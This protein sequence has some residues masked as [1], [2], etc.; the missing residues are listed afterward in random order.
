MSDD[1]DD[2]PS[3]SGEA[4]TKEQVLAVYNHMRGRNRPHGTGK[5]LDEMLALGFVTSRAA[6]GRALLGAPGREP[7]KA[8]GPAP[9]TREERNALNTPEQRTQRKRLNNR[10]EHKKA[11]PPE[12]G[13][14]AAKSIGD[15]AEKLIEKLADDT[16]SADIKDLLSKDGDR[17]KH[18]ST[19]L[20][21]EENR[22]RMAV[23]IA[24]GRRMID[25]AEFLLL[26]MRGTAAL[27]D[28]LTCAV[29]VSGGAAIDISRPSAADP[30]K[31]GDLS[32]G[33]HTMKE[34][35]PPRSTGLAA[36]LAQFRREKAAGNGA[37]A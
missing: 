26:D 35:N 2:L 19:E 21:I 5:V 8:R 24:L 7:V 12:E 20:A 14:P 18:S 28:A 9:K 30:D 33:G 36:D 6:I 15:V 16:L 10:H 3:G 11:A 31:P 4:P 25:K 34:I 13:G 37:R 17:P 27:V 32:P 1:F 22:V 23:N 29:K